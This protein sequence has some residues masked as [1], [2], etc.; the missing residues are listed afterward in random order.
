MTMTTIL[1]MTIMMKNMNITNI[2]IS[3]K[4]KKNFPSITKIQRLLPLITY[5]DGKKNT[6]WQV[7]V[8]NVKEE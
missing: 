6:K 7:E 8:A 5:K 2:N 3:N 1:N 4:I